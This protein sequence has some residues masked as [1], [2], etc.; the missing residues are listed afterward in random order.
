MSSRI[1]SPASEDPGP[2]AAV[3]EG[4][5]SRR[6]RA[7]WLAIAGL[8]VP[9]IAFR[10]LFDPSRVLAAGDLAFFHL[11]LRT[12]LRRAVTEGVP[13]WNTAIHGGQP[14]LSNPNY[15]AFYP[16]TWLAFVLP[17]STAIHLLLLGHVGWAYAGAWRLARHLG[18]RPASALVAAV[19]FTTA[20]AFVSSAHLLTLFCGLA[21][22]PWV[23]LWGCRA[24]EDDPRSR[25]A[26]VL[27]G[28]ALASQFLAGEPVHGILSALALC[29]LA[30]DSLIVR[31]GRIRPLAV[32]AVLALLLAGVQLLPTLDRLSSTGRAGGLE[33]SVVTHRSMPPQRLLEL[34]SPHPFG[35]PMRT[36]EELF[37]GQNIFDEGHPYLVSIYPGLVVFVLAI[38]GLARVR[39]ERY[40]MWLAMLAGGLFLALGRFNPLYTAI[41]PSLPVLDQTRYPEKMFLVAGAA[42]PFLAALTLE[43]RWSRPPTARPRL[44]LPRFLAALVALLLG[45]LLALY[46]VEPEAVVWLANSLRPVPVPPTYSEGLVRWAR[47]DLAVGLAIAAGAWWFLGEPTRRRDRRFSRRH[48]PLALVCLLALDLARSGWHLLPVVPRQAVEVPPAVLVE[49]VVS[50]G[51]LFTDFALAQEARVPLRSERPGPDQFWHGRDLLEPYIATLWGYDYTLHHD[52]DLMLTRPARRALEALQADWAP[53]DRGAPERAWRL[54]GAWNVGIV[55]LTRPL[56]EVLRERWAGEPAPRLRFEANPHRLPEVRW[57]DRAVFHPDATTALEAAR[58]DDYRPASRSHWIGEPPDRPPSGKPPEEETTTSGVAPRT[59]LASSR[60][61]LDTA[62]THPPYLQI[63][64]TWD[65]GWRAEI[66][67]E[68]TTVFETAVGQIGLEVPPGSRRIVLRYFDP[69]VLWGSALTLLGL[70]GA[71]ILWRSGARVGRRGRSSRAARAAR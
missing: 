5:L 46:L 30:L 59:T 52:Y 71:V 6:G 56:A 25:R 21:W 49:K 10:T 50:D 58:D 57:V 61:E 41:V 20:G 15:A 45:A 36:D 34:A 29:G 43:D 70:T 66:D 35:D 24:V 26:T 40:W 47:I 54:L 33:P 55:A 42:L 39:L 12:L 65:A 69:S 22:T 14:I 27:L 18:C 63:A 11:P 16:P 23:L 28:I 31:R 13:W 3:R 53:P 4:P 44:D 7:P 64:R 68:A 60:V 38:G 2:E 9:A 32:A 1:E 19:G 8:T 62:V 67:G 48:V 51:R 37:Y 17:P